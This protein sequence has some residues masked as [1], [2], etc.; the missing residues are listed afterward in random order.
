M[1]MSP[2]PT[3]GETRMMINAAADGDRSL[4]THRLQWQGGHA[5]LSPFKKRE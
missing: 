5:K 1:K 3:R 4:E 2:N